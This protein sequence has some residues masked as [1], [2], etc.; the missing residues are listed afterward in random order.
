MLHV[1]WHNRGNATADNTSVTVQLD[2]ALNLVDAS[3]PFSQNGQELTF[4]LGAVPA[5]S[6]SVL[7][8]RVRLHCDAPVFS[9]HVVEARI[10]PV[11]LCWTTTPTGWNGPVLRVA[12]ECLGDEAHFTVTNQGGTLQSPLPYQLLVDAALVESGTLQPQADQPF[13]LN[14]IAAGRTVALLTEQVAGY[15]VRSFPS[16]VVE[17]CGVLDN[18]FF[19][20][21]FVRMLDGDDAEPWVS[22][23]VIESGSR[24]TG[25]RI[26]EIPQGYGRYHFLEPDTVPL[27][28]SLRL[29][30][31]FDQPAQDLYLALFPSAQFDLS[32]FELLAWSHPLNYE[33]S[34]N[35]EIFLRASN[36]GLLPGE[37]FQL[38]F[39]LRYNPGL[40]E[41]FVSI[42]SE[43]YLDDQGPVK[44]Y[45]AFYN[46]GENFIAQNVTPDSDDP[47]VKIF[48]RGNAMD[49]TGSFA[50]LPNGDLAHF[51]VTGNFGEGQDLYLLRS[52]STGKGIWQKSYRLGE[53]SNYAGAILPLPDNSMLIAGS[54]QDVTLEDYLNYSYAYIAHVGADGT[55]LWVHSWKPGTGGSV[56]DGALTPDGNAVFWGVGYISSTQKWLNFL[57]KIS[58]DNEVLWQKTYSQFQDDQLLGG[59]LKPGKDGYLYYGGAPDNFFSD[60]SYRLIRLN[61]SGTVVA[62]AGYVDPPDEYPYL[63]DFTPTPDGGVLIVGNQYDFDDNSQ[64]YQDYIL[65]AKL[66]AQFAP[67][68]LKKHPVDLLGDITAVEAGGGSYFLA[69]DMF[70][71]TIDINS[72]DALMVKADSAGELV[73]MKTFSGNTFEYGDEILI[74]QHQRVWM[75]AQTQAADNLYN[76]QMVLMRASDPDA[77]VKTQETPAPQT[78]QISPNP[79]SRL[80]WL[81]LRE[82]APGA[83]GWQYDI[84]ASDDRLLLQGHWKTGAGIPVQSLPNGAYLLRLWNNDGEVRVGRFLVQR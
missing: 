10:E 79:A 78:V 57:L 29:A 46:I 13:M 63:N 33:V 22:R 30:N 14:Y 43:A 44:P 7:K 35:G 38:R 66:N 62:S 36:L 67:E 54:F 81:N 53:G 28:F 24:R 56:V 5:D 4:P 2:P 25:D 34:N 15:P 84:R 68:W 65:L 8:I 47:D 77:L 70:A 50:Q 9:T 18:G 26:F 74:G 3:Q 37:E 55:L 60:D 71:D 31:S 19:S 52:D 75:S 59:R 17:G 51:G 11:S 73:W 39:R 21:G 82:G 41:D 80:I 69:G 61:W 64:D 83:G 40:T 45:E 76:L 27:E 48:G 1:S 58:P 72:F 49:F 42:D 23:V 16:A 12:G 20:T 32:T 6:S